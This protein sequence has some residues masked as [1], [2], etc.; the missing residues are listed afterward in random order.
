MTINDRLHELGIELPTPAQPV[1]NYVPFTIWN[2]VLYLAGQVPK[3]GDEVRIV[4]HVG[5]E[6][7]LADAQR[8]ACICTLQGLGWAREALG[9]L[10]RVERVLRVTG[11]VNSSPDFV[12]QPKV[13]DAASKL[14]VDIFGERG[15]HARSAVGVASLPRGSAVEIELTLGIR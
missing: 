9:E 7:S 3:E 11:F 14:L 13:L 8:A 1:F 4:G 5:G 6:V 15:Q 10:E 2:D 12:D